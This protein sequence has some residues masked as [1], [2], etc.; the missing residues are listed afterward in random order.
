MHRRENTPNYSSTYQ[1]ARHHGSRLQGNSCRGC[2][3]ESRNWQFVPIH[4]D[5][6]ERPLVTFALELFRNA[7]KL[8]PHV[9]LHHLTTG[10]TTYRHIMHEERLTGQR[11]PN[12]RPPC[13]L[14]ECGM[15]NRSS[16]TW[17]KQSNLHL[18]IVSPQDVE[19]LLRFH[20][21]S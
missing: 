13:A 3:R 11:T 19:C 1:S 17:G 10:H 18:K 2:I 20:P 14:A 8:P 21:G 4:I 5:S 6:H 16:C 7:M 12:L 9:F 15:S